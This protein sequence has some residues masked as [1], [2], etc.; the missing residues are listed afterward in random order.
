MYSADVLGCPNTTINPNRVIS[1]PTEIM[2]VAIATSTPFFS[3]NN[4]PSLRLASET[5]EV[6]T[7]LVSS[8]GS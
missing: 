1:R 7:R 8:T 6:S 3:A 2:L 5:R 4:S